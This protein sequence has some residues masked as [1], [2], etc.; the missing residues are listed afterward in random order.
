MFQSPQD[1]MNKA[2][3]DAA[4]DGDTAKCN[5]LVQAGA[6]PDGYKDSVR[7]SWCRV[8]GR[9]VCVCVGGGGAVSRTRSRQQDASG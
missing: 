6:D 2:L 9:G 1:K 5:D 7:S 4:V 8:I 3:F